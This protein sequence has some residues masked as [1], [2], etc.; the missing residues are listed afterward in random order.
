MKNHVH[1]NL[2]IAKD[3]KRGNFQVNFGLASS[4]C[5]QSRTPNIVRKYLGT[6]MPSLRVGTT[7]NINFATLK[8]CSQICKEV[9]VR[10]ED[11]VMVNKNPEVAEYLDW[12]HVLYGCNDINFGLLSACYLEIGGSVKKHKDKMNPEHP[13]LSEVVTIAKFFWDKVRQV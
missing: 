9:G 10:W 3:M 13:S 8:I 6:S 5:S 4:Q 2:N 7:E 11:A 12:L 1:Q